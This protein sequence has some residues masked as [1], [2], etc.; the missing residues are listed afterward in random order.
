MSET[1]RDYKIWQRYKAGASYFDLSK[2][3]GLSVQKLVYIVREGKKKHVLWEKRQKIKLAFD[4]W[5]ERNPKYDVTNITL[6][7]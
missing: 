3:F 2:E 7:N 4:K 1:E 5:T 6:R